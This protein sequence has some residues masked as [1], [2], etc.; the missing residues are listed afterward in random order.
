ML[1]YDQKSKIKHSKFAQFGPLL[2]T[3]KRAIF[4]AFERIFEPQK[5]SKPPQIAVKK[6]IFRVHQPQKHDPKVNPEN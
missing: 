2:S 5:G 6:R 1:K 3:S 4:N